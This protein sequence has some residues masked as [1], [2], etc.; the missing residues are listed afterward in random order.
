MNSTRWAPFDAVCGSDATSDTDVCAPYMYGRWCH[1]VNISRELR[2]PRSR[3]PCG[4]EACLELQSP[5][6]VRRVAEG[7]AKPKQILLGYDGHPVPPMHATH[8]GTV[9]E[10]CLR[11]MDIRGPL[12]FLFIGDSQTGM[13]LPQLARWAERGITPPDSQVHYGCRSCEAGTQLIPSTPRVIGDLGGWR[14]R[15]FWARINAAY[16]RHNLISG[17]VLPLDQ[18]LHTIP[19]G[20]AALD[21]GYPRSSQHLVAI[22]GFQAWDLAFSAE[23]DVLGVLE[24]GARRVVMD[25]L[26]PQLS[27]YRRVDLIVRNHF[28]SLSIESRHAN[29][30]HQQNLSQGACTCAYV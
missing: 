5:E 15:T 9:L 23:K 20:L 30:Q 11:Q 28:Y 10:R 2:N 26:L 16:A 22:V 6:G 21:G 7:C 4:N 29:V 3:V 12:R 19:Q 27:A 18:V 8:N 24:R 25:T 14:F 1:D 13:L 17:R